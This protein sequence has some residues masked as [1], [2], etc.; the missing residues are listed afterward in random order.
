MSLTGAAVVVV[1][2]DVE[3]CTAGIDGTSDDQ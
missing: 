1:E 2:F 3:A